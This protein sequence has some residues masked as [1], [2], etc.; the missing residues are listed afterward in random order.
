MN[1]IL[2]VRVNVQGVPTELSI[3]DEV[4]YPDFVGE[5]HKGRPIGPNKGKIAHIDLKSFWTEFGFRIATN[6]EDRIIFASSITKK[7]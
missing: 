5:P 6:G 2:K 4:E 7:L 1:Q 3:G